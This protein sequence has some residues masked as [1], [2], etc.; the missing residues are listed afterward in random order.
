MLPDYSAITELAGSRLNAEQMDRFVQRYAASAALT[1]GRT[2]EVASGAAIGLG[3]L[4][5]TGRGVVGLDSTPSVLHSAQA[6][7]RGRLPLLCADG[8]LMPLAGASFDAVVCLEA[9]YYMPDPDAFLAEAWR[10]LRPGGRL[11]VGSSNPHW[12]QFV[13]GDLALR[14]P[15]LPELAASLRAAGFRRV[16]AYGGFPLAAELPRLAAA[17]WLRRLLLATPLRPLITPVAG[18]LKRLVYGELAALPAELPAASLHEAA[19]TLPLASLSAA[20]PD[21]VHRVIYALGEKP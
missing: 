16:Q 2:L 12:P 14:Y 7:Y 11:L 17:L 4:Q 19:T 9:I 5:A 13:P 15:S 1:Q 21:H 18:H 20:R 6:Y 8:E 3:G 10:V